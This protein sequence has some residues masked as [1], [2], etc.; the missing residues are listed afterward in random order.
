MGER[1]G[2]AFAAGTGR[3]AAFVPA[4]LS[5]GGAVAALGPRGRS[6]GA[7]GCAGGTCAALIAPWFPAGR[8]TRLGAHAR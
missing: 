5:D 4:L 7:S 2:G 3:M 8:G 1:I 6:A